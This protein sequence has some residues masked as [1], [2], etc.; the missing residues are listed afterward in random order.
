MI[1]RFDEFRMSKERYFQYFINCLKD[2]G[3]FI[4]QHYFNIAVAGTKES[5]Y[6]E[7]V[8]C[9]ELYHHLRSILG[10]DFP[11]KLDG[12]LDKMNHPLIYEKIGAKKPD[13]VVHVPGDMNR[14]LV[15]IEVKPLLASI[16]RI[17]EDLTTLKMFLNEAKYFRAI[18]LIYGNDDSGNIDRIREEFRLFSN[19]ELLLIWHKEPKE[20]PMILN[21]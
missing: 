17:L 12:E 16:G 9:Y 3:K 19:E 11:Y 21:I 4:E 8:Y 10:D 1:G 14:N 7:R 18:M 13:F 2:A 15:V 6:R 20:F 5:V